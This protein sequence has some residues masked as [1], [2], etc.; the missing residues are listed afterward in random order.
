[1][2]LNSPVSNILGS[3]LTSVFG[4][5][6]LVMGVFAPAIQGTMTVLEAVP[7]VLIGLMGVFAKN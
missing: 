3:K 7:H 2:N 1:M 6:Y 4:I 5:T